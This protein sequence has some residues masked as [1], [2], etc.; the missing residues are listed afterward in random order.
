MGNFLEKIFGWILLIY[1]V[2][3]IASCSIRHG[4]E[5]VCPDGDCTGAV[6]MQLVYVL[7]W[8]FEYYYE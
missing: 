2:I 5:E 3:G 1:L 4:A 7:I 6:T 8:P